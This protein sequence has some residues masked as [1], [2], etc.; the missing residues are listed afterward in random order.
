MSNRPLGRRPRYV[1]DIANRFNHHG[2]CLLELETATGKHL[3]D[4][5]P[6]TIRDTVTAARAEYPG[7]RVL[8]VEEIEWHDW[9]LG[10]ED[11]ATGP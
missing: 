4:W 2:G 6:G 8:S 1:R 11:W 5:Y 7:C 9:I 10:L 3:D